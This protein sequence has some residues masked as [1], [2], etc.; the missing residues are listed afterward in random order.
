MYY[1]FVYYIIIHYG[2]SGLLLDV[3]NIVILIILS[4][5]IS[6]YKYIDTIY[7]KSIWILISF[8]N[9]LIVLCIN[10]EF[11]KYNFIV[12]KCK[13]IL[14]QFEHINSIKSIITLLIK[15]FWLNI[16]IYLWLLSMIFE[17]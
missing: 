16:N 2:D 17:I 11:Y 12:H 13:N 15:L 7:Y 9:E 10:N 14:F 4:K 5:N 6:L 8:N 1:Y 3:S